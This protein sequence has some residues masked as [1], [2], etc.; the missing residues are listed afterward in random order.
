MT[1]EDTTE[2]IDSPKLYKFVGL[3]FLWLIPCFVV[4][5]S[6]SAL[7][8]S[9]AVWI[10]ET[11]MTGVL[12]D[13]VHGLSLS[14]PQALLS[15]HF[16]ELEGNIV[17]AQVAG[18]RLAY[19]LNTRILTYSLPFYAALHFATVTTDGFL[20]NNYWR[21]TRGILLLY[22]LLIVGII[23]V[24]LKNLMLGLGPVF[25]DIS[26]TSGSMIGMMY[27]LSTLM[28][29][30]LA[31]VLVWAWQSRESPLLQKLLNNSLGIK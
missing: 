6:L 27:Q 31:P 16:G 19:P 26:S 1:V 12:P 25:I 2:D 18:Y 15:T 14:G 17:S 28:V 7:L 20:T 10:S 30:S 24:C 4:W 5:F 9:P 3:I 22:P 11:I 21:F 13:I 29:P 23:S 8:A